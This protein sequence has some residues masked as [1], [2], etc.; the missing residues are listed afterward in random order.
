MRSRPANYRGADPPPHPARGP[1][2]PPPTTPPPQ[3]HAATRTA[4]TRRDHHPRPPPAVD[5]VARRASRRQHERSTATRQRCA[6]ENHC[7][8]FTN[9]GRFTKDLPVALSATGRNL[10]GDD[11]KSV[12][13]TDI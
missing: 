7:P 10:V 9:P 5:R 11:R 3:P 4:S 6:S 8:L 1:R 2:T 13:A 12:T